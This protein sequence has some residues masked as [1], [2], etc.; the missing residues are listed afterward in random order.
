MRESLEII[1]FSVTHYNNSQ[2][3]YDH[4]INK[5]PDTIVLDVMMRKKDWVSLA[6]EIRKTDQLTPIIF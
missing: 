6:S 4:Y 5:K 2:Q 3:A 1:N